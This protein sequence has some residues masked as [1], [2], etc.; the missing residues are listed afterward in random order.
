MVHV[1]L[2]LLLLLC[3]V[4]WLLLLLL[5]LLWR[6]VCSSLEVLIVHRHYRTTAS[7]YTTY[8]YRSCC[9]R[10]TS[11]SSSAPCR[12]TGNRTTFINPLMS[13]GGVPLRQLLSSVLGS[14][15]PNVCGLL[16]PPL[17]PGAHTQHS[18]SSPDGTTTSLP[19]IQSLINALLTTYTATSIRRIYYRCQ[20]N[21]S[22]NHTCQL[23][24]LTNSSENT[25]TNRKT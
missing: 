1:S 13:I 19:L 16:G 23:H 15:A 21:C 11:S 17:S 18:Y 5:L 7:P 25:N 10:C 22:T 14:Y 12:R 3:V 20:V 4:V 9:C 2:L 8:S 6:G 24:N